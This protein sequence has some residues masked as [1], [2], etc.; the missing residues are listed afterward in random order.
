MIKK[1]VFIPLACLL[2]FSFK[3]SNSVS[4][5]TIL[6]DYWLLNKVSYIEPDMYDR[7]TL[8]NDVTNFCFEQSLWRFST[9]NNTGSYAINDMY[10]SYGKRNIS[11]DVSKSSKKSGLYD[12]VLKILNDN[13]DTDRFKIKITE[14]SNKSMQWK[15]T[16]WVNK[17]P[18][19]LKMSF[20]KK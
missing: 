17:K 8:F 6:K 3:S 16:T 13:G 1:L 15:Y 12:V 5:E 18:Y 14:L 19:T 9:T 4:S 2:L 10:C 20:V 11:F 7:I